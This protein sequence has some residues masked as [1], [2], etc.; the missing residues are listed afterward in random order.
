[1]TVTGDARHT[2][3]GASCTG[4][5]KKDGKHTNRT[6]R[7]S[8][9]RSKLNR[10]QT[11]QRTMPDNE[12]LS[13]KLRGHKL[14][15]VD[16]FLGRKESS[17]S[18]VNAVDKWMGKSDP[19]FQVFDHRYRRVAQSTIIMDDLN[20]KWPAVLLP[21]DQL[22]EGDYDKAIHITLYDFEED[23]HHQY[24][25]N[26]TTTVN[27]LLDYAAIEQPKKARKGPLLSFR[28][29]K[30]KIT[31]IGYKLAVDKVDYG[32]IIVA[33]AQF[34]KQKSTPSLSRAMS[35]VKTDKVK[36]LRDGKQIN[37][38]AR[39]LQTEFIG[40]E[41]P[42]DHSS[43][44]VVATVGVVTTTKVTKQEKTDSNSESRSLK[45]EPATKDAS[46]VA[47]NDDT[48]SEMTGIEVSIE[49]GPTAEEKDAGGAKHEA[50]Q[51]G[52]NNKDTETKDIDDGLAKSTSRSID[53]GQ[54]AATAGAAAEKDADAKEKET[55]EKEAAEKEAAEKDAAEEAA[56][57]E[58]KK[59]AAE[60]AKK[61][62]AVAEKAAAE[63][64][65][66]KEASTAEKKVTEEPVVVAKAENRSIVV[67]GGSCTIDRNIIS[68][69]NE[70]PE[71]NAYNMAGDELGTVLSYAGFA[72]S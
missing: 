41:N 67:N 9:H 3:K 29:K 5:A 69:E 24:M 58:A 21:I 56:A 35:F 36:V 14:K 17:Y 64:K 59:K 32:T 39:D 6:G 55:N 23:Q 25:G 61:K 60:D 65:G 40:I 34:V 68:P 1:M 49:P 72:A 62:A 48:E 45:I 11:G 15:N 20:P 12:V 4:G 54:I 70:F 27:E 42:V 31:G 2:N 71:L 50:D 43:R 26:I 46:T 66:T 53:F 38:N 57:T 16:G 7:C 51:T 37:Y 63:K 22:C 44:D 33:D 28:R 10:Y 8:N 47:S 19:F 30:K 18:I 13:L 52:E